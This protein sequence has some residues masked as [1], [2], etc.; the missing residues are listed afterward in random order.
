MREPSVKQLL[1]AIAVVFAASTCI[2][3][4]TTAQQ[5]DVGPDTE[6]RF[7]ALKLPKGFKAT[8]FACDPLI[9]YPSVIAIGPQAGTLFVAHDYMT[10]LGVEIVRRDEVRLIA[11]TDK[12][13]YADKSTVFAGGF[14]SIQGL[15]FY[16][17][18]VFVMHAPLLTSIR[19]MDGDGVADERRDLIKG[20]GLP[21]EENSNRLHC[22]NGVVAG[23]DGWLYLALGDRGCDVRRPEG[24]WLLFRQGGILR[25][26]HDGSD[27][28]VFSTGLRNIYDIALDAELNVF[29][30]DNENDGGDYMIRVN[31]CFFGSD[32]GYPYHYYERPAEAMQP[33]ADLG[34]GSSAG[35]TSYLETAF[36][37]AYRDSLYF[38]EWGRAVVRYPTK[39]DSSSFEPTTEIDFA[40]AAD[41]DPY[42]FK[43]TD[44][45][46]DRDGSLLISDWCDG[47]RPKRGRGRIYRISAIADHESPASNQR[48][49]PDEIDLRELIAHLD[50]ASHHDRVTAQLAL[51]HRG[52]EA[53]AAVLAAVKA[54]QLQ[55][56]G[57]LHAVWIIAL[58]GGESLV[59]DLFEIAESDPHASV[60]AQAIRA[61][62][63]LTDPVLSRDKIEAGRGDNSVAE[64]LAR[65]SGKAGPRVTLETLQVFRRLRWC[66]SPLWIHEN[67]AAEDPALDHAAQQ[68]LRQANN[69]PGVM[70]LLDESPRLRKLAL[71]ATAEQRVSYLAM[72]FIDR[73]AICDD[74]EHRREYV[75]ALSRIAR[76][77]KPWTYWGFRPAPRTAASVDW[78]RTPDIVAAL[79]KSLSGGSHDV[80][81]FALQRMLREGVTPELTQLANW[82]RE[83][84]DER[85]VTRILAALKSG[86]AAK[87]RPILREVVVRQ[88]LPVANRIEALAA[89][90]TELPSDDDRNLIALGKQLEDGPVLAAVL[91]EFDTR[92]KL[93]VTNL[94]LTK[95]SSSNATVRAAAIRSL[96]LRNSSAGRQHV[97][98]LLDDDAVEVQ[99]AAAE[100]AGLLDVTDA[101]DKLLA[102]SKRKEDGLVRTSLIS[103]RQ[104]RDNR[105]LAPAVAALK[106]SETQL[107]ALA[108]L[109]EFATPE[110]VDRLVEIAAT[111][112]AIEFQREVIETLDA[113]LQRFPGSTH[114]EQALASVQ[115]QSGQPLRWQVLGPL[116][117]TVARELAAHLRQND[118]STQLDLKDRTIDTMIADAS[119][120]SI[121][122]RSASKSSTDSVW[123]AWSLVAV[124]EETKIEILTSTTGKLS[125]WIDQTR[126]YDRENAGTYRPD[127]DRFATTLAAGTRLI[128][129]EVRPN[130]TAT[131]FHL[132]F[133]RRSSKAEHERLSQ[134]AL[135]SQGNAERGR[136]VFEDIKKS[137]CLQ[138]HRF[139]DKG[140]KIG[141]DLAGIGNR[142]SRIHLIESIL[143]PSRTVAPSY[144]TI[145]VAMESGLVLAGVR[146]AE[147]ADKILLGD[148]QGKTHEILTENI[149]KMSTQ[150][151][152]TMPEGL[153][154]KLTDREFVDLLAFLESQK[155]V[156]K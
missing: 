97:E 135:Q 32:H 122:F 98:R 119:D 23:H 30:R 9:E 153:E 41:N 102:L 69:W 129:V 42:G 48:P 143:E 17:S 74:P 104:L 154:K 77:E 68:S 123:L 111:N 147:E 84:S 112:P 81:A 95:I 73:L 62:G 94:L 58:S 91:K 132:R 54:Q 40:A 66:K 49:S 1:L 35:G 44:L 149:D 142:F 37:E 138:C 156:S 22:A 72:E 47:Q 124:P 83:E 90:V 126:V 150:R 110:L 21:P 31:H 108:Y 130:G 100:A 53:V 88:S 52:R 13:G 50:S 78:R 24:D 93:D 82:L 80:R 3:R 71:H 75:D 101:A 125:V 107:A 33:L 51:Q 63:D 137:S 85:R 120:T 57:R 139:G 65:L 103:L 28:H 56:I 59:D 16:D 121:Q 39:R 144:A 11:D 127:S 131:R 155:A 60:R 36:P 114:T 55:T 10:G 134:Y 140:G 105:A 7:P 45:V 27:L 113:W 96:G 116:K 89:F 87:A 152:S 20:L 18:T 15:A 5:A 8:L 86:H 148:N 109:R 133:R 136:E 2:D 151:L 79:N 25:C 14:N 61:I 12:D 76:E 99:I 38:C 46:V 4:D 70:N 117:E 6:S 145:V 67:L 92:T 29:V 26:R 115:G 128:A 19:D 64:R 141:P 146:I 106:H 34:R 43:P 118:A